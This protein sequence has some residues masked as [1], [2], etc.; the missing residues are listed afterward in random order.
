M[1]HPR[2]IQTVT[3]TGQRV[4]VIIAGL[5][6]VGVVVASI[7]LCSGMGCDPN[8]PSADEVA[9]QLRADI[10]A[11]TS[12]EDAARQL[13]RHGFEVSWETDATWAGRDERMDYLYGNRQKAVSFFSEMRW[14]V[15]VVHRDGRVMK[16]LVT[17]GDVSW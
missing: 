3:A 1:G 14:Q 12:V 7:A 10:P 17:A 5:C 16:V 4:I 8:P 15:A 11:G 2:L 9:R 6:L 13:R